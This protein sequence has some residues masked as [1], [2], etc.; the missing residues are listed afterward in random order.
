[1]IAIHRETG[2]CLAQV[3]CDGCGISAFNPVA[4]DPADL[5]FE[6][7]HL[8]CVAAA[9]RRWVRFSLF[10]GGVAIFCPRCWESSRSEFHN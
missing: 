1:M 8:L 4:I 9:G 3:Q 10:G 2:Q 6:A 7:R 5:A